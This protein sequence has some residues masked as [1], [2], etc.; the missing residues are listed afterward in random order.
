[1][2]LE[3]HSVATPKLCETYSCKVSSFLMYGEV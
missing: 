1:V 3:S 2:E